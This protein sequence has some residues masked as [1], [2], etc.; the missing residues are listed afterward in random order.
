LKKV[1]K[2]HSNFSFTRKFNMIGALVI[3]LSALAACYKHL[4]VFV[5]AIWAWETFFLLFNSN[6]RCFL[7]YI[8]FGKSKDNA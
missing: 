4:G 1:N 3:M 8:I 2:K 5:L 6:T 7:Q